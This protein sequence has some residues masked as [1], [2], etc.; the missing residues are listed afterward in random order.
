MPLELP[1]IYGEEFKPKSAEETSEDGEGE[2][3]FDFEDIPFKADY[4]YTDSEQVKK[5]LQEGQKVFGTPAASLT[6]GIDGKRLIPALDAGK[7]GEKMTAK[8]LDKLAEDHPALFTFHSLSWPESQGD[9]DHIV[10]YGDLM[11]V[12]DSKRWKASRKYSITA[13]GA[14]MRGTVPFPEGKVKIG[15]ALH[16]WRRKFPKN[17]VSG[18]VTIA[19]EKVF[20]VRDKNWYRAPYRLV[21]HEKL[22]EFI[23]EMIQ[24]NP[25]QKVSGNTLVNLGMLLVKPRDRMSEIIRVGGEERSGDIIV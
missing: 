14:I 23:L 9:T 4:L 16:V 3:D 21:E 17:K 19:Q 15:S 20:V 10:V 6:W 5:L 2:D 18:V 1:P 13:K 7:E 25:A 24:K 12:I 11:I 22:E 8:V